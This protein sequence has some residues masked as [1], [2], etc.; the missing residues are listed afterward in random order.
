MS[1][2]T[3]AAAAAKPVDYTLANP[4]TL[5]KYKVAGEISTKVL[6]QIKQLLVAD[7]RIID[8]CKKGDELLNEACGKVY[9]GKNVTKGVG[10]PTSISVNHVAAHFSPLPSDSEASKQLADGDLVKISLGAQIDGFG[11]ILGDT[12][13]VG[14]SDIVGKKADVMLAAH[15]ASEAAIRLIKPGNKNW[16]VTDAVQKIA[17]AFGCQPCE[18]ILSHNQE[19]NVVDGKKEIILNPSENV[20]RETHSFEQ[21]EVYGVD[22]LV[23]SGDGKVKKVDSRTTIF[24]RAADLKYSLKMPSSRKTL[25]E[26]DKTFGAFPFTLRSLGDEKA[27]RI[28]VI[29]PQKHGLLLAYEVFEEKPGEFVALFHTTIALGPSGTIKLAGPAPVDTEKLKS[30]KKLEDEELLKLITAPL[31]AAKLKKKKSPAAADSAEAVTE[32]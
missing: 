12:I 30:D 2:T 28:G 15:L 14:S 7:A 21:G 27:A 6:E 5:T 10:F 29:E 25:S 22:I 26:I 23:S 8:I 11:A 32:A 1:K 3:T 16:D 19:R 13:V 20:K 9:K 18:G 4:D 24:K 31:K 17:E